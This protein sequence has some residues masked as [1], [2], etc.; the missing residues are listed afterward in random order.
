MRLLASDAH[1]LLGR[2]GAVLNEA[3]LL[4]ESV[5]QDAIETGA[6]GEGLDDRHHVLPVAVARRAVAALDLV[7]H[8]TVGADAGQDAA[9]GGS[10]LLEVIH[11]RYL[12]ANAAPVAGW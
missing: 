8:A 5:D 1:W 6:F 11:H 12:S 7:E 3:R 10:R 4:R 2:P 9:S